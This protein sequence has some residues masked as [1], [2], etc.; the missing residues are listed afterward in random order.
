MVQEIKGL[1]ELAIDFDFRKRAVKSLTNKI[2][3]YVLA[4]LDNVPIYVG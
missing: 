4:D 3:T 2:G 1:L